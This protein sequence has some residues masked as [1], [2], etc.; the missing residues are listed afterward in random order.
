MATLE[1]LSQAVRR[2]RWAVLSASLSVFA[3]GA[4]W[5]VSD[6][7]YARQAWHPGS[8]L[9]HWMATIQAL[10]GLAAIVFGAVGVR[11]DRSSGYAFVAIFLG[12]VCLGTAT[13]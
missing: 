10:I 2:H 5:V 3:Y 1:A 7:L 11:K 12:L 4:S 6:V 9:H 8:R 13:V